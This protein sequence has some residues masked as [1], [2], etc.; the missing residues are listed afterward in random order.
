[1][2]VI[3][4][5]AQRL[6]PVTGLHKSLKDCQLQVSYNIR[7]QRIGEAEYFSTSSWRGEIE[8]EIG[9]SWTL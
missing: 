3:A 4:P 6:K 8:Y 9:A 7:L 2:H 5:I 1:M